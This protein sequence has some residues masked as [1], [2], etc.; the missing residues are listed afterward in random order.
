MFYRTPRAGGLVVAEAV[1]HQ[2]WKHYLAEGF[3]AIINIISTITI[4]RNISTSIIGTIILTAEQQTKSATILLEL[5][6][7]AFFD[8]CGQSSSRR[9]CVHRGLRCLKD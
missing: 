7:S 5:Q 9:A 4:I 1:G 6:R 2:Q 8:S 3:V